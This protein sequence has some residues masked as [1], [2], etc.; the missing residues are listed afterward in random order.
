MDDP[1]RDPAFQAVID[2]LMNEF[3]MIIPILWV[4]AQAIMAPNVLNGDNM[5]HSRIFGSAPPRYLQI[6]VD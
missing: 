3:P 2:H 5:P 1:D 4:P 6:A